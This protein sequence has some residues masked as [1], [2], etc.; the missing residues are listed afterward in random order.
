MVYKMKDIPHTS[1]VIRPRF[2]FEG[3]SRPP[4]FNFGS[5]TNTNRPRFRI[6]E[7]VED[8]DDATKNYMISVLVCVVL[9]LAYC[10]KY[11]PA[12][13][14]DTTS[15]PMN[16]SLSPKLVLMYAV[17][18]SVILGLILAKIYEQYIQE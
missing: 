4:S 18:P 1:P 10:Y 14:I 6:G 5:S 15:D 12:K 17:V 2:S 8:M 13:V 11:K 7:D 9:A 3:N 16:P